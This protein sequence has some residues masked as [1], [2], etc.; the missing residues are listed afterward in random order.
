MLT[1]SASDDES[2]MARLEEMIREFGGRLTALE[3]SG[4]QRLPP[5]AG[6][7]GGPALPAS[8]SES[9]EQPAEFAYSGRAWFGQNL[10]QM[11]VRAG[12][13]QVQTAEPDPVA[14]IFAA[15]ASPARIT[16]LR[17]LLDG[18]RTSQ[19]LRG[20]LDDAS[21]G[22]LYHHL[23]E[24]LAAGLIVQPARSVYAITRGSEVAI[25]IQVLAA[26]Q[27]SMVARPYP[28]AAPSLLDEEAASTGERQDGPARPDQ[29]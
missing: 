17:A 19:Q 29:R 23:R 2:R 11:K 27:L 20:D 12:M 26:A 21:V 15:L 13:A 7:P 4:R 9:S 6:T 10:M 5:D 8:P 16:L 1:M 3:Q 18:P 25:C 28:A 24:L 22:Q 14:Q